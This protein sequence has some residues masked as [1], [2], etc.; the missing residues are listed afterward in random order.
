MCSIYIDRFAGFKRAMTQFDIPI[1]KNMVFYQELN[2]SNARNAMHKLFSKKPYPDAIFAANDVTALAAV[3]FAKEV[4]I[5]IPNE[6]KVVGY[7]NDPRSSIISPSITTIEQFPTQIAKVIVAE[8][9]KILKK[10]T[11][12]KVAVDYSPIIMPVELIRR[13]ST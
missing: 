10:R 11:N 3:G 8:L 6:L 12:E 1:M 9:L 13:M 5:S 2:A 7:S 4:G